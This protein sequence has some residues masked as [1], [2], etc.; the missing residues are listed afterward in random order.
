MSTGAARLIVHVP[1][2]AS[3]ERILDAATAQALTLGR[4]ALADV[5]VAHHSVSR[6]HARVV[7]GSDGWR[8][9]DLASKNGVR[10]DGQRVATAA[11]AGHVWF[12]LG[13]VFCE[14][15]ELDAA[16]AAR[17]LE[18]TRA[19]R[20]SSAALSQ[21]LSLAHG[22]EALLGETLRG[23][24]A[25][26]EC[27]RGFILVGSAQAGMR[28]R[29]WHALDPGELTHATFSGSRSAVERAMREHRAV[30]L[31][32]HRD[33]AWLCGQ[34]SV[35]AQGIRALAC[36]PLLDRGALLGVAYVDTDEEAKIFT[37]LDAEL[38]AAFAERA[39][40]ALALANLEDDI[41]RIEASFGSAD[42]AA[43][44]WSDVARES[45]GRTVQ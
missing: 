6:Q 16:G 38:L 31:S 18:R 34:A 28:L 42:A 7:R 24:V 41:A 17:L 19:R 43:P 27:R 25:L 22:I 33:R 12:A 29:A 10:L 15:S 21:Q 13:D 37:D 8:I 30:F 2:D 36:L 9:E 44:A 14:F 1:G 4:D 11:L 40:A 45:A 35:I 20:H 23:M 26:A 32:D 5:V 39:A 3:V